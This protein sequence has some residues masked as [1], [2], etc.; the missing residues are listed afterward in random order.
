[1]H[2]SVDRAFSAQA[3]AVIPMGP[4]DPGGSDD[5][6]R[7]GRWVPRNNT[8]CSLIDDNAI[9]AATRQ[10]ILRRAGYFVIAA[11]HP[12][13]ALEQF[14]NARFSRRDLR[15]HHR[16]HHARHERIAVRPRLRKI[17]PDLP[18][19]VVSGMD[20]AEPEYEGMNV[21][22]LL[23]PLSPDLM[24]PTSA[25]CSS[26][27]SKAQPEASRRASLSGLFRPPKTSRAVIVR[28]ATHPPVICENGV[29]MISHP[30]PEFGSFCLLLGLILTIYNFV[31]GGFA[32]WGASPSGLRMTRV[33]EAAWNRLGETARRAGIASFI[34]AILRRLRSGLGRLHQRLLR[35]LHPR[36]LEHRPNPG[37]QIR[38]AMVRPGGF[39]AAVG[40]AAHRLR[41]RP[42]H[43]P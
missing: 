14:Q 24:L 15:R 6:G 23:K 32:L 3:G 2:G 4:D 35:R 16:P 1:M 17:Q 43:A 36:P 12:A 38:R 39:A 21:V 11:L 22:F 29:A 18:V 9:Q 19:M 34:A 30:M 27:T 20:E 28:H 25:I 41:L 40:L 8:Q 26:R 5:P 13:R 37:I 42:P 33:P 10:A 31:L 7:S